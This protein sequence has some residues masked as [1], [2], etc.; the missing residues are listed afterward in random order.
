MTSLP[1]YMGFEKA[2]RFLSCFRLWACDKEDGKRPQSVV[3]RTY[4][5]TTSTLNETD[6]LHSNRQAAAGSQR[7]DHTLTALKLPPNSFCIQESAAWRKEFHI[8]VKT[9]T[10]QNLLVAKKN[11]LTALPSVDLQPGS[12][13]AFLF[14]CFCKYSHAFLNISL[15]HCHARKH[16]SK[17]HLHHL[18]HLIFFP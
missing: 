3:L 11:I 7:S 2:S 16:E 6:L 9:F 12:G 14:V 8:K 15:V 1:S 5:N 13:C 10:T 17:I 4:L 18:L